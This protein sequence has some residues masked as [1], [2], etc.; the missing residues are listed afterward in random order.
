MIVSDFVLRDWG[1]WAPGLSSSDDWQAWSAGHKSMT[2]EPPGAPAS[3]PKMLQ[4]RLNLLAKAVFHAADHCIKAGEQVPTVF[5]STHGEIGKS[6]QMLKTIEAGE[7]LSP[8]AF[9]LSV[10]NAISGLFSIVYDNQQESTVIAP[11]MEGIAAAFIE[12]AGMLSEGRDEVLLVLYDEPLPDFF[13]FEPF[14]LNIDMP[15]ALALKIAAAG[16]GLAMRFC[17]S[18]ELRDDGEQ[19]VQLLAF[20]KFLASGQKSLTL[21]NQK[22]SWSW[23]KR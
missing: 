5:S 6:F 1:A 19:P 9:S 14:K 15:C 20:A 18:P 12:A 22:H 8:T 16:P 17:R 23:H 4:R 11:G 3:V 13:P 10:H 2:A 21:G 7:E